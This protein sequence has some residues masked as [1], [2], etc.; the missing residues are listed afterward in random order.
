MKDAKSVS[1]PLAG[2]LKLSKKFYR[3][4][5][6]EKREM[7]NIPYS[8]AIGSLMYV[9]VCTRSDI[10][11]AVGVVSRFLSNPGKVYWKGVKWILKYLKGSSRLCLSFGSSKAVLHGFADADMTNDLDH[12]KSISG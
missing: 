10:A 7:E 3:T 1:T 8:L 9:M 2:H 11:H 12:R 6:E 5:Y 4:T